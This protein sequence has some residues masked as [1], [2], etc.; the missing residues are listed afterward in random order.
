MHTRKTN[1]AANVKKDAANDILS[2]RNITRVK[3]SSSL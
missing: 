2:P 1:V 3:R